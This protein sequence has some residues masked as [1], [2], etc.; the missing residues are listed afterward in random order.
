MNGV[1]LLKLRNP[2]GNSE[3]TGAWSDK[4]TGWTPE[5]KS[6][7]Q[8]VDADDGQFFIALEDY[9]THFRMTY[10][11]VWQEKEVSHCE[12]RYSN[13]RTPYFSFTLM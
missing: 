7:L 1:K 12:A 10:I 3:W 9:L 5:L 11:G 13:E 4:W 8:E 2:W 6:E